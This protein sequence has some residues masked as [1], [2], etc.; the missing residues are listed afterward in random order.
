M[1][2]LPPPAQGALA[3][4]NISA[5]TVD[6]SVL[7]AAVQSAFGKRGWVHCDPVSKKVVWMGVCLDSR[8]PALPTAIDCERPS[9]PGSRRRQALR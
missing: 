5:G 8:K 9:G 7:L 4:A 6:R 2:P 1:P 3:Q